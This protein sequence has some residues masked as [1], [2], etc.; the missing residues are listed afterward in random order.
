MLVAIALLITAVAIAPASVRAN[1]TLCFQ[2]VANDEHVSLEAF[3]QNPAQQDAFIQ[4]VTL[5]SR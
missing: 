5:C 3:F 2:Q 1:N 4:A